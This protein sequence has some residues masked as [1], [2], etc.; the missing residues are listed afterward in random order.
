MLPELRLLMCC[1]CWTRSFTKIHY[2]LV[3][4]TTR[5]N[6]FFFLI[7]HYSRFC[8]EA[9]SPQT[10]QHSNLSSPI[11]IGFPIVPVPKIWRAATWHSP[12]LSLS[13]VLSLKLPS[14]ILP[15]E[16]GLWSLL[17]EGFRDSSS[18]W[19]HVKSTTI[20][21]VSCVGLFFFKICW[22]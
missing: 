4:V 14:G 17:I 5:C 22:F 11:I 21:F 16:S 2:F 8:N 13:C 1:R 7:A 15:L 3:S 12:P 18:S 10:F 9:L 19:D 20:F 6:I